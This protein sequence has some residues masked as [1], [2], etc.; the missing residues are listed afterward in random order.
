MWIRCQENVWL[1]WGQTSLWSVSTQSPLLAEI[2]FLIA[3]PGLRSEV[4]FSRN[5]ELG[6]KVDKGE[7]KGGKKEVIGIVSSQ[8]CSLIQ[9]NCPDPTPSNPLLPKLNSHTQWR[10]WKLI[11][12][13]L[14]VGNLRTS[15]SIGCAFTA[16]SRL[17]TERERGRTESPLLHSIKL[18]LREWVQFHLLLTIIIGSPMPLGIPVRLVNKVKAALSISQ[19][20]KIV[21][22]SS[23]LQIREENRKLRH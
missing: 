2:L 7:I 20:K 17:A 8:K 3:E 19:Q 21:Y 4:H 16:L 15:I 18:H 12:H 11:S 1:S 22:L 6:V 5:E 10:I 14:L 23:Q 13:L 9:A